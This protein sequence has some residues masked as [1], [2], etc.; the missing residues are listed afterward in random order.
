MA[1]SF[2]AKL[3]DAHFIFAQAGRLQDLAKWA[4]QE[5]STILGPG[6][7]SV[8]TATTGRIYPGVNLCF[9]ICIMKMWVKISSLVPSGLDVNEWNWIEPFQWNFKISRRRGPKEAIQQ[10]SSND[11]TSFLQSWHPWKQLLLVRIAHW[12]GSLWP[13]GHEVGG[14]EK[15]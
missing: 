11:A 8:L 7:G 6:S 14:Y 12:V 9:L 2:T 13:C 4:L 15:G 5:A 3:D 1:V 10:D